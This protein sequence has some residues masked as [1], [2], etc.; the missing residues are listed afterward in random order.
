MAGRQRRF[1]IGVWGS[2]WSPDRA[3]DEAENI[4]AAA[5][6]GDDPAAERERRGRTPTVAA[7]VERYLAERACVPILKPS[8][9]KEYRRILERHVLPAW[10]KR[11]LD[12]VA[13]ADVI[14]LHASLTGAPYMAN[15][16]LATVA[17]MFAYAEDVGELPEGSSP[18]RGVKVFRE[19][20]RERLLTAE[21]LARLGDALRRAETEGLPIEP[22]RWKKGAT[23]PHKTLPPE[24]PSA[25]RAVRLILLTGARR[26]EIL[27]LRW[28]E[29][30]FEAGVLRLEDSK[31]GAKVVPLGAPALAVLEAARREREFN[32]WVFPGPLGRPYRDLHGPWRRIRAAAGLPDLRMHDLRHVFGSTAAIA[33]YGLTVV[34]AVL[35]HHRAETTLRYSHVAN[36]PRK[37]LADDVAG[38]LAA[39]LGRKTTEEGSTDGQYER[40]TD[41]PRGCRPA[42]AASSNPGQVAHDRPWPAISQTRPSGALPAC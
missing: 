27:N 13:R 42:W 8:T 40:P 31:T 36:D 39:A 33:G 14:K 17:A 3:R 30:D 1:A 19:R 4:R 15:R 11:R 28:R 34:G 41:N 35:G 12:S 5:R 16:V 20:K 10:G 7:F 9:A 29:V 22:E 6:R 32:E 38:R 26:G 24:A 37:A 2:A 25:L 21:E 23:G 18:A